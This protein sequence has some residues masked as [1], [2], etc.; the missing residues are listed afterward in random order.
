MSLDLK[1]KQEEDITLQ[2][3]L[4]LIDQCVE[5]IKKG[6]QDLHFEPAL[7]PARS[8]REVAAMRIHVL[9]A[10]VQWREGDELDMRVKRTMRRFECA[11]LA[12]EI[13]VRGRYDPLG[14]F[15]EMAEAI[16]RLQDVAA[17][18]SKTPQEE[19][20]RDAYVRIQMETIK[21]CGPPLQAM[22][23][24]KADYDRRLLSAQ[25]RFRK[26]MEL[27]ELRKKDD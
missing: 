4:G 13:K 27:E 3:V 8:L 7:T 26:K 19:Q 14:V 15:D 11:K 18:K 21:M 5:D 25:K 10:Q 1:K 22:F 17:I 20:D 24:E 6:Y 16:V 9:L 12:H 2:N 23:P